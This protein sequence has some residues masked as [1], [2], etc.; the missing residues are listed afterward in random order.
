VGK[1][2][3]DVQFT[4]RNWAAASRGNTGCVRTWPI[5]THDALTANRRFQGIADMAGPASLPGPGAFIITPQ[6]WSD[7]DRTARV[8]ADSGASWSRWHDRAAAGP[9]TRRHWR[10]WRDPRAASRLQISAFCQLRRDPH[11]RP[12]VALQTWLNLARIPSLFR[13]PTM[14]RAGETTPAIRY[15]P[16]GTAF[17]TRSPS[18]AVAATTREGRFFQR[19]RQFLATRARTSRSWYPR[20][21]YGRYPR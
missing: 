8:S 14:S 10:T 21:A 12:I 3:L 4:L 16:A 17:A 20:V 19:V 7:S 18:C 1:K 11:A 13:Q 15:S 6:L 2:V 9:G 5:A